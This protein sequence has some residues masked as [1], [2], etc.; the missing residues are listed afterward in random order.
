MIYNQEVQADVSAENNKPI[1]E[2]G[3]GISN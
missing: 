2:N 1:F 3:Y